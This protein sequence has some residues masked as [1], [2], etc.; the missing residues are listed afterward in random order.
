[1]STRWRASTATSNASVVTVLNPALCTM[2]WYRPMGTFRNKQAPLES[3]SA[4]SDTP[5]P[6]LSS[7]T[8]ARATTAAVGSVTTPNTD[9]SNCSRRTD[10]TK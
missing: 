6:R 4:E 1:M 7:L 5:V 10:E 9:A 3:V 8:L 2:T